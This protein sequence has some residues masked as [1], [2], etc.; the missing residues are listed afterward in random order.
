M[1]FYFYNHTIIKSAVKQTRI[2]LLVDDDEDDRLFLSQALT[3][4]SDHFILK[5]TQTR[6][7]LLAILFMQK[8]SCYKDF[9]S[10]LREVLQ[11]NG[12]ELS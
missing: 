12:I 1:E 11:Q 4:L 9:L 6:G 2:I 7:H 3:V 5:C 10:E 8:P